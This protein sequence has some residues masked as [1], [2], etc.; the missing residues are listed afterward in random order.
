M[1]VVQVNGD[2]ILAD[3][4]G[5]RR[6]V[7]LEADDRRIAIADTRR[8]GRVYAV[9]SPNVGRLKV[10]VE[11]MS[12][13]PG[14]HTVFRFRQKLRPTLMGSASGLASGY[15]G[16]LGRSGKQCRPGRRGRNPKIV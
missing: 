4:G 10:S 16:V 9:E 7:I 15:V 1:A 2:L 12:R 3:S 11:A 5:L 13:G 8:R 6:Q 14:Y